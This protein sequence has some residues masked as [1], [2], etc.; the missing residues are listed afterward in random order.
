MLVKIYGSAIF[1]VSAQT[2]TIEVNVDTSGV[3]YH[4]VGLPDNAIKESSYR[5]S[6]ALKN[7]G[8]KIPGKKITINMAPADLRKEG[9][10]YDLSIA[11]GIL[12]ASEQIKAEEIGNYIIMGELSLD[13]GLLP[14]KGVLPI[15]IKA[16]EEGFKGIIL[17]K[18][19]I[20][21]A[22]IVDQL[23]VY[24]VENIKEVIDFFNEGIP[25]ERTI[26]DTRKEF[27]D[28]INFFPTDFSEVKGQETAKRA[29]EV[30]AAG[31]HNIIL[32][33]PP[34]SGKTML[35]KRVPSILPPLT[36]KEALETTK[37]HSVAG[38]IGTE[39][40]LMTV[41]PFRSP[42]H[43]ISDVALVG[44]GSYPQPGEISLA[45]NGVLFLDEMPEF[46]RTVLEVMRQ[47]LEDREVTISRA[48]FTVNY[49]ASF[50]LVASMNPSPSGYFPDDPN[51]TSS[52]FEMQRYMNKLSGPLLDRIDIHIEVQK[53]EFDQL[54]DRRKGEKSDE[55]RTRV[56]KAREIQTKRYHN[57]DIHYNAQ[58]GPK[59]IEKYCELDET[60]QNLIKT[61]MEKLNL[62][63]RAYD[64]ILKVARTI[65]DLELAETLNS[66]HIAEAIQYRS[67]DRE[68]WNV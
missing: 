18:Q 15:A 16:R 61:A 32:I 46:K 33:G 4:L 62:S 44:G 23:E 34:G 66:S 28:K 68:F 17:P 29:M 57:A 47:P 9:S 3:G 35:A 59:E 13:G 39:T 51:N 36:L 41:R 67:L 52:Q 7:V 24:G 14:I 20:R 10:A 48:K 58:M 11:L 8:F 45:H 2:I 19:N 27:Q 63:A 21:E 5:I 12:S 50:M 22:A 53:V 54:S 56:L 38:K 60:S 40:S 49:P 30:A 1:G 37:I 43:T 65:A 26:I 42:H 31:G 64:R 6:A 25:L 55:I